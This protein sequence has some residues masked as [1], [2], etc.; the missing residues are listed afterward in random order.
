M[1]SQIRG[2]GWVFH[3]RNKILGYKLPDRG[4][5]MCWSIVVAPRFRPFFCAL[6]HVTAS[7]HPHNKLGSLY[8]LVE[9]IQSEQYPWYQKKWW[10]LSKF[11]TS[12]CELPWVVGNSAVCTAKFVCFRDHI[13]ST[14]F[15]I[16]WFWLKFVC[17][18]TSS[19]GTHVTCLSLI[20]LRRD[21][22]THTSYQRHNFHT[23]G[24]NALKS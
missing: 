18:L 7:I 12:T 5:F 17:Q 11:V 14:M 10:A 8:G 22:E 16:Q 6:L 24:V 1:W 15:H 20:F 13:K 21:A 2:I 3:F 4:R 19:I 23:T 9:W